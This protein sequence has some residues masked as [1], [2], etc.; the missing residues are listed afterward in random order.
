M[1]DL[2]RRT[3]GP[4]ISVDM[5]LRDGIGIVLCDTNE[6]ESALLNLSI[7]ARDA[8]PEGGRLAIDT[9]VVDLSAADIPDGDVEPGRYVAVSVA[10]SGMGMPPEVLARV[11]DPFFTT[12]P[13]GEGTGLGLSQVWSFV[14]QSGG[15]VRIESTPGQG[16]TVR[17]LLPLHDKMPAVKKPKAR[18]PSHAAMR[19]TVLLVDDEDGARQPAADRLRELGYVVLEARDGPGAMQI[20]ASEQPD[21]LVTDVGLPN[22]MNGRQIAEAVRGRLPGL[23]VLYITGYAVTPLPLGAEVIG[24]PFELDV[25]AQRVQA[26]LRADRQ[27]AMRI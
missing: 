27:G 3:M 13:Q 16:T 19:A 26:M 18:P 20:L 5:R 24:K 1:A 25:L 12:K 23:P 8:M 11:F 2:I 4:A 7:N 9:D 10:D 6:L 22:G 17:L 21:V 15:L 14:R